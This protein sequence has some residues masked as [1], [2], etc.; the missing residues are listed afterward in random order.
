VLGFDQR[1]RLIEGGIPAGRIAIK[2]DTSPVVITGREP[3]AP[4]PPELAGRK[5]L[6]YSGNY[7]VPHEVETVIGGFTRHY[8]EG[9]GRV[10]LWLNAAG[11]GADRVETSLRDAGV[12]V[13]RGATVPL[14]RL[15]A[16]LSA[17]DAH[18]VTLRPEFSGIVLPSKIYACIASRRPIV[19]VGPPSSDVHRLSIDAL[20]STYVHINPGDVP[21]FAAALERLAESGERRDRHDKRAACAESESAAVPGL[22]AS[23]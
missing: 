15:P 2:R 10:G 20:Q 12:A 22:R 3:P 11:R 6:L 19:F 14:D 5:V 4:R 9:S 7:G 16:L 21:G 23:T 17:A 13:A 18:L 1:Q 8:R